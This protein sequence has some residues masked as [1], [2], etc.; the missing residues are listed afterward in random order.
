MNTTIESLVKMVKV[1]TPIVALQSY[2]QPQTLQEIC[3]AFPE[4]TLIAW[5]VTDGYLALN[6]RGESAIQNLD[7]QELKAVKQYGVTAA[8]EVSKKFPQSTI[9]ILANLHWYWINPPVMQ[10]L[11]NLR[12]LYKQSKRTIVGLVLNSSIPGDL[13]QSVSYLEEPLPTEEQL[14]S[15][16]SELYSSTYGKQLGS[17]DAKQFAI[18]LRGA[19]SFRAEQ[20]TAQSLTKN[21]IDVEKLRSNCRKQINDTPGLSVESGSETFSDIGG[22][23]AIREYLRRY[24]SGPRKPAV[25]VRI[26]EIEK[27]LAGVGS[28]TSGTSGDALGTLLTAME[29]N[30]WTGLL[31]YGVSGCGK[32]LIAKASANEF[33]C[34]A[35]RFDINSCKGSLV[36]ESEKQIRQ[37]MEV[38][39]AIGGQRV[40]FIASMNQIASLP[41]ELRRRF[42]AGT[43]YFDIPTPAGRQSIWSICAKQFNVEYDGYD[44]DSLTGAD[45]RDIVQRSYELSCSTTEAA[46]YHVPLC[47][48]APDAIRES[49]RDAMGRYLC[50]N[51]G[52]PYR[53]NQEDTSSS[54]SIEFN[55]L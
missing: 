43:W 53:E 40:F 44:S 21:G 12:E 29:D 52:G 36:G 26:E 32:S 46:K 55:N 30:R 49:R 41:P 3:E 2:D 50:A 9:L 48:S 10:G 38:L 13:L 27:A 6:A 28:E 45:I 35:I 54:R 22:L 16:V 5:N 18:E 11:L 37:A 8:L 33:S 7:P 25:V 34:K 15:K 19:S 47:K 51:H 39:K 31:A 20:L 4:H 23:D 24:F 42:S 1:S 14:A 17:E